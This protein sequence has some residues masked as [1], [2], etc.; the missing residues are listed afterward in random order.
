MSQPDRQ[1]RAHPLPGDPG[2]GRRAAEVCGREPRAAVVVIHLRA[3]RSRLRSPAHQYLLPARLP[4]PPTTRGEDETKSNALFICEAAIFNNVNENKCQKLL[5]HVM[6]IT[7]RGKL[8][9]TCRP[10][11]RS[12]VHLYRNR[13]SKG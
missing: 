13:L 8:M 5:R 11:D 2:S 1:K 12:S 9:F 6:L 7:L 4:K 10:S 3:A